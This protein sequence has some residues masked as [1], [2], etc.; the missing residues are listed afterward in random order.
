ML[1]T[2]NCHEFVGTLE[3]FVLD[4][5][6]APIF[7]FPHSEPRPLHPNFATQ[8]VNPIFLPASHV[9]SKICMDQFP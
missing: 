9:F 3:L 1:S 2:W 6:K 4:R 8:P 7:E 5:F